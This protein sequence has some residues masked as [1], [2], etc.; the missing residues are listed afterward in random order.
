MN[1]NDSTRRNFL[2]ILGLSATAA[3]ADNKAVAGFINHEE[4]MRL[5]PEQ[6][7]FMNRYGMWMDEFIEVIRNQKQKPGDSENNKKMIALTDRAEAFK[8]E[9]AKHMQDKDFTTIYLASIERMKKE[10]S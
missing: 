7:E 4:I 9:L 1:D 5:N 10:I 8:P 6:Q 2:K 3:L